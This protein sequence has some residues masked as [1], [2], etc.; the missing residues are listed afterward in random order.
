MAV[1][2]V[3]QEL[4]EICH[5]TQS[6]IAKN[7]LS[8]QIMAR[9]MDT[10]GEEF[11]DPIT[12]RAYRFQAYRQ[13]TYF[14]HGR[15]GK[16]FRRVVP[17]CAVWAIRD[18]YP[19]P[20]G[21][22]K[23]FLHADEKRG[24]E[25]LLSLPESHKDEFRTREFLTAKLSKA[26]LTVTNGYENVVSKLDE[27]LRRDDTGRLWESFVDFD[28]FSRGSLTI[29]E[30]I[31]RFD[32]LYNKLN[33]CGK[34]TLP[35][36]VLGL[37]LVRRANLTPD[38]TKLVLT[39]NGVRNRAR[40]F[41]DKFHKSLEQAL[42]HFGSKHPANAATA[43]HHTSPLFLFQRQAS[44]KRKA[45]YKR[46][47]KPS[48]QTCRYCGTQHEFNDRKKSPAYENG[49]DII[50]QCRFWLPTFLGTGRTQYSTEAANLLANLAAD[51]SEAVAVLATNNR[52]S[53]PGGVCYWKLGGLS[54]KDGRKWRVG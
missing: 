34:V 6:V 51:W 35:E 30:Y 9:A 10:T 48:T 1:N 2:T 49:A 15:L 16:S 38:E 40:Y 25:N 53:R 32:I 7:V 24:I 5:N 3:F 22:Y 13:V 36:S 8:W 4:S 31:S 18:K 19:S 17:S 41:R 44:V 21:T 39:D 27:H 33:K 54:K 11:S 14:L 23:G 47:H 46:T 29:T 43:T 52:T 50:S 26:E 42:K 37:I 45:T 20:D 12:N 28:S